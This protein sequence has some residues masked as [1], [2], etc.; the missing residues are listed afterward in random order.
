MHC[1]CIVYVIPRSPSRPQVS[2]H[3]H[4]HFPRNVCRSSSPA[5]PLSFPASWCAAW[6]PWQQRPGHQK[7]NEDLAHICQRL[8]VGEDDGLSR[9]RLDMIWMLVCICLSTY[10]SIY[11]SILSVF[12]ILPIFA[13]E[14]LVEHVGWALA[15]ASPYALAG[16]I[17][18][19]LMFAYIRRQKLIPQVNELISTK[20]SMVRTCQ[21]S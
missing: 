13:I 2:P 19:C 21:D 11:P 20:R 8:Y 17:P 15:E 10:L 6:Q 3:W 1:I 5:S 12:S 9:H 16:L 18:L 4:Q 7:T 14:L